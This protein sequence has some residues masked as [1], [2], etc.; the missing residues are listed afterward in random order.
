M[1]E[2]PAFV[3]EQHPRVGAGAKEGGQFAPKVGKSGT[4]L[5]PRFSTTFDPSTRFDDEP[6]VKALLSESFSGSAMKN[7]NHD[8]LEASESE[9]PDMQSVA[10]YQTIGYRRINDALRACLEKDVDCLE[11]KADP[12][13]PWKQAY[14][15]TLS[16]AVDRLSKL[17]RA[18]RVPPRTKLYRGLNMGPDK[19][20]KFIEESVP[21]RRIRMNGF[22]SSTMDRRVA[23]QF[24]I[25]EAPVLVEIEPLHG[26]YLGGRWEQTE[27][28]V[29]Q[30][31]GTEYEVV[32]VEPTKIK[33]AIG[34]L[35]ATLIKLREVKRGE[36]E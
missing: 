21:G 15:V 23:S 33:A 14:G 1:A 4:P 26:M 7:L 25:S 17:I 8:I 20:R 32:S 5:K 28:E 27:Y 19:A 6:G 35:D 2:Q 13:L 29:I 36:V 24:A 10:L 3:E 16:E 22:V 30:D 34:Q 11:A 18:S 12:L 9:R 31:H